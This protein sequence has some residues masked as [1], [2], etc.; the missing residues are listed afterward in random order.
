MNEPSFAI[1]VPGL[2]PERRQS[3]QDISVPHLVFALI[4]FV[5]PLFIYANSRPSGCSGTLTACMSNCKNIATALEMYS[6]DHGGRY[7]ATLEAAVQTGQSAAAL[8]LNEWALSKRT[9]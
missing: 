1:G 4:G 9:A 2:E 5:I 6:S 3:G 8:C 7:P